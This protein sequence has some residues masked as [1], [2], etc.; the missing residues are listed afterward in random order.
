MNL[1]RLEI[2]TQKYYNNPNYCKNC[3][4]LIHIT[5]SP[6]EARKRK[7]CGHSCAASFNNKGIKRHGKNSSICPKCGNKKVL[8]SKT[9][10]RC[11]IDSIY[12]EAMLTPINKL[13][14]G[15]N[16]HTQYKNN[17]VRRWAKKLLDYW[18]VE[19]KCIVCEYDLHVEACH[20]KPITDFPDNTP[21]GIVNAK[22]NLIYLCRNCHWEFDNGYLKL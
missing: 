11:K 22:Y 18:E 7:F 5:T 21:M 17:N 14:A 4:K 19:K 9:C 13:W 20:I 16:L 12:E 15:N 1:S 8:T 6:S 2:A 10:H 3:G